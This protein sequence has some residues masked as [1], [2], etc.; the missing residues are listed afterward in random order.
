[1]TT[2]A[3]RFDDDTSLF[4]NRARASSFGA[5]A[6]LYDR[7]RPGYP[8]ELVA[9]LVAR[10]G[11]SVL[12]VGCGTGLL[13]RGFLTRGLAV[14]GVEPDERMADVARTHGMEVEVGTFEAW[15]PRGRHFDLVVAGQA[16]HWVDPVLGAQKAADSLA[17]GG[18][19]AL[20]WN[21]GTME[22]DVRASLDDVYD[23]LGNG[24]VRPTVVHRPED[25]L[26][27]GGSV[28]SLRTN[29]SFDEPVHLHYP[30]ERTYTTKEWVSQLE[31]HSDHQL[32]DANDRETLLAAV[33][34]VLDQHGGSFVMSYVCTAT[35]ATRR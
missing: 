3:D 6:E 35:V 7:T 12:D 10:G 26:R 20:V 30:W 13:S 34:A 1:M 5:N 27:P 21:H 8:D 25:R 4:H 15:D 29:G 2:D 17:A 33:S 24:T 19:L 32:L 23:Q 9:D 11:T 31:T 16:W 28:D 18:A 14:T 22:P